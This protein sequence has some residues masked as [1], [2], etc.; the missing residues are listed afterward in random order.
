VGDI[1]IPQPKVSENDEIEGFCDA[2]VVGCTRIARVIRLLAKKAGKI[3]RN[4]KDAAF[5][6]KS[7][8]VDSL[9]FQKARR[10]DK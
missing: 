2:H 7:S 9:D 1:R 4:L 10:T 5:P 3:K 6:T 8:F